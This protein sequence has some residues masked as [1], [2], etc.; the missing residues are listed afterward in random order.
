MFLFG[1][2]YSPA[3]ANY[4][5]KSIAKDFRTE[6]NYEA[7]ECLSTNCYVDDLLHSMSTE[8]EAIKTISDSRAICAKGHLRLHKFTSNSKSVMKSIP[9]TE[10]QEA[11]S[12]EMYFDDDN[13]ERVLGLQWCTETDT[14][15]FKLRLR[16]KPLTRRGIISTVASIYDP[17]GLIAPYTLRG[18]QILQR[19]CREEMSWD[20]PLEGELYQSWTEWTSELEDLEN[21]HYKKMLQTIKFWHCEE[22]R[23]PLLRRC[24][25]QWIWPVYIC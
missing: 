12:Q 6:E 3:C 5:L 7:A 20:D 4:A 17:L 18:K 22:Y 24:L 11:K 15:Q 10:R 19:M 2:I 9:N 8:E 16:E 14:F 23:T 1:A 21:G 25:L 13:L